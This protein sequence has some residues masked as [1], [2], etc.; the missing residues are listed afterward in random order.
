MLLD[1]VSSQIENPLNLRLEADPAMKYSS[2][3]EQTAPHSI[4]CFDSHAVQWYVAQPTS[5]AAALR[6]A[7]SIQIFLIHLF[8]VSRLKLP[9]FS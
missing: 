1:Y 5:D 2:K 4:P 6:G 7:H 8:S 9:N 3:H